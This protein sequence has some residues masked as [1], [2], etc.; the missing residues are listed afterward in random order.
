V[1]RRLALV[2]A[3]TLLGA[4]IAV[5]VLAVFLQLWV[6]ERTIDGRLVA[7]GQEFA[8]SPTHGALSVDVFAVPPVFA[9]ADT[10]DGQVVVRSPNLG[11]ARLPIDRTAIERA[12]RGQAWFD[13]VAVNGHALR[14]YQIPVYQ[15][16][17]IVQVA[18]PTESDVARGPL[19]LGMHRPQAH[20][21]VGS[22]RRVDQFD[23]RSEPTC[24]CVRRTG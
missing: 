4:F 3:V 8:Q 13:T 5:G 6:M 16:S 21:A 19:L 23:R 14:I 9:Q 1:R 2:N 10:L 20:R 12:R 24:I 17:T 15:Q 7:Q 22:H 11:D 18:S